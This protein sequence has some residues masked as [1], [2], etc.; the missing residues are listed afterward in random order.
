MSMR[1]AGLVELPARD[2]FGLQPGNEYIVY[3]AK[4]D[5]P[6]DVRFDYETQVVVENRGDEILADDGSVSWNKGEIIAEDENCLDTS[7]GYAYFYKGPT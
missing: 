4:D 7:R 5:D 3:W 1:P 6:D 2:L